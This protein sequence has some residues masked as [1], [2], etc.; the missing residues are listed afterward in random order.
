M[1]RANKALC[2]IIKIAGYKNLSLP[3]LVGNKE[4]YLDA[5]I[6]LD[7]AKERLCCYTE[8][9]DDTVDT[10]E[11]SND[12]KDEYEQDILQEDDILK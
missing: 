1:R 8:L 10:A 7:A 9:T 4:L 12:N 6:M 2:Q 3:M 5:V 11:D